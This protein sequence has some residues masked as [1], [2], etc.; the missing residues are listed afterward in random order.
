M[1]VLEPDSFVSKLWPVD[2]LIAWAIWISDFAPLHH[3]SRNYSL[4]GPSLVKLIFSKLP[5]AQGSKILDSLGQIFLEQFEN[6]APSLGSFFASLPHL[7]IHP[8][9]DVLHA[10]SW[11][12]FYLWNHI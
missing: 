6:Y 8:S 10:E 5:S 9:L 2:A 11:H 7:D 1:T 4:N 3:E 12:A